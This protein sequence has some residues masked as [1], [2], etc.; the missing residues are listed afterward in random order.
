M[1]HN[2]VSHC[3]SNGIGIDEYGEITTFI[4]FS[5]AYIWAY[6]TNCVFHVYPHF[7]CNMK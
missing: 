2:I 3:I 5:D 1:L 4:V 6:S 7:T